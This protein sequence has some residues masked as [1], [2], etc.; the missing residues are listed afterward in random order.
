MMDK[1]NNEAFTIDGDNNLDLSTNNMEL[2]IYENQEFDNIEKLEE[3]DEETDQDT[4][5]IQ[6][7]D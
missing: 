7:K 6:L 1:Q 2:S 3:I 4:T 5:S